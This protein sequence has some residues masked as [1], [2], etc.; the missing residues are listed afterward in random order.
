METAAIAE[1][2]DGSYSNYVNFVKESEDAFW[3]FAPEG[4]WT[5]GQHT[6]HLLQSTK[7]LNLALSLPKFILS[8]KY[9]K[10]NREVRPYEQVVQRYQERLEQ[11]KGL[12]YKGSQNMG[13]PAL[14]EK[15]YLLDR[16]QV[17]EKKLAYKTTHLSDTFL[18]NNILP[19]PLMGKMPI[20][21]II[22]WSA[23][24]VDHHLKILKD[25]QQQYLETAQ[26]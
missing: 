6:K 23:Y 8:W 22:M 19:H 5:T 20:R 24:H 17:E 7:P 13:V 25:F 11:S 21:E 2:I 4:K 3:E 9:G 18:N 1:L 26:S 15:Q 10:S 12:V 14:S 16:I